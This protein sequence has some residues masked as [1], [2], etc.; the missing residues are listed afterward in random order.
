MAVLARLITSKSLVRIQPPL[1]NNAVAAQMADGHRTVNP[2]HKK[3][4]RFESYLRHKKI[5]IEIS[6]V[7]NDINTA[8]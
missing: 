3:H 8:G 1:L 7:Y 6:K 5:V 4:S 2:A